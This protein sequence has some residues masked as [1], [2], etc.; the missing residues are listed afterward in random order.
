MNSKV[1]GR[2][3]NDGILGAGAGA[4]SCKAKNVING[5]VRMGTNCV[6]R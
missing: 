6:G 5:E 4:C 3:I 2:H 1:N